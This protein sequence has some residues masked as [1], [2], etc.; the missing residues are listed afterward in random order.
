M[1]N[2]N[3]HALYDQDANRYHKNGFGPMIDIQC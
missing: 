1:K 3:L 2:P